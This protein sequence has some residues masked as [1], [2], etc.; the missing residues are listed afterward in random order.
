MR[1]ISAHFF[2]SAV[3]EKAKQLVE[4]LND[5]SRIKE[6]R[7]NARKLR[8]KYVG[9]NNVGASSFGGYSGG[10]GDGGG[11]EF[12]SRGGDH[13]THTSNN[14]WDRKP[15]SR[16]YDDEFRST[17]TTQVSATS[18]GNDSTG[19]RLAT[20]G[21]GR[22]RGRQPAGHRTTDTTHEE[23]HAADDFNEFATAGA[24]AAHSS[25]KPHD[26]FGDFASSQP[27]SS[28]PSSATKTGKFEVK[29]RPAAGTSATALRPA[30]AVVPAHDEFDAFST[31]VPAATTV[32][33]AHAQTR[34]L[35]DDFGP[36]SF[37]A[38]QAA[39]SGAQTQPQQPHYD[40]FAAPP[41]QS[42]N[43]FPAFGAANNAPHVN[44]H[45]PL[46]GGPAA[47]VSDGFDGFGSFS[48][49]PAP[50]DTD[51]DKLVSLDSF[52][53][54]DTGMLAVTLCNSNRKKHRI[55]VFVCS[56]VVAPC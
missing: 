31:A 34:S 13:R 53:F 40:P 23:K 10:G 47:P 21:G 7:D 56:H 33:A 22:G 6:E 49:A 48:S 55:H 45:S 38:F 9:I 43:A 52:N 4:L 19:A 25:S 3:R 42:S 5:N 46:R 15:A 11:N 14:E 17:G 50:R 30:P 24:P 36:A 20:G 2:T 29:L 37:S 44:L 41:P 16:S 12:D 32:A 18:R 39:P 27:T 8:D 54:K 35:L 1:T 51:V 28:Q 26:D